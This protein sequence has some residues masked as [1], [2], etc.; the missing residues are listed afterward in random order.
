[1]PTLS[2]LP[3]R[4]AGLAVAVVLA[5]PAW[6]LPAAAAVVAD[7]PDLL[8]RVAALP[9][10]VEADA[11][12]EAAAARA[13]Q[14]R[15]L[16]NPILAAET[17]N[18]YGSGPYAGVG[19]AETTLSLN[20]PLELWGQR[21]A[22]IASARS[23]ATAAGLRADQQRWIA[24]G[25]LALAYAQAE[26]AL[27]RHALAAE[28]LALVQADASAV[29]ALV[30]EGREPALRGLQ[31]RSEVESAQAD[32]EETL[33]GREAALARLVAVADWGRPIEALGSSLLDRAVVARP[34]AAPA[35]VTLAERIAEAE[36]DTAEHQLVV[37]RRRALPEVTASLG[38]RRFNASGDSA[39][40][41]GLSLSL[42]LFDRNRGGIRAARAEADAAQARLRATALEAQA[43]RVAAEATVAA[44]QRRAAAADSGV[45]TASEAYRLARIGFEAGR[46]SQLELR[47]SRGVLIA[48]RNAAV[49]ARVARVMAEVELALL[50]G[51][52]PFQEAR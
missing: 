19:S 36:R 43:A 20:Q 24:A 4:A 47:A 33:A 8:A 9:A 14:A 2:G 31:A 11:L 35:P 29:Q 46:I 12:R 51:R 37:E 25:R 49:D 15:A 44:S 45:E 38:N 22:R 41:L 5:S 52:A 16:P 27:R 3:L 26:A 7:Y 48:A 10:S 6:A 13:E 39:T 18:V 42:P 34:R 1:M 32:V 40:T 28:A 23:Q 30:R 17:E 21:G 50:Q